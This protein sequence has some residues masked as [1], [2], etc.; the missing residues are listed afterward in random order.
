MEKHSFLIF[1]PSKKKDFVSNETIIYSLWF[2]AIVIFF[3]TDNYAQSNDLVYWGRLSILVAIVAL[4][5]YWALVG[6]WKYR[7]LNGKYNGELEFGED[8]F[9]I[10]DKQIKLNEINKIDIKIQDYHG[11]QTRSRGSAFSPGLSQG[12]N[13]YVEYINQDGTS[14]RVFFKQS[15]K[16]QYRELRTF[17]ISAI[18]LNKI[19]FLRGIDLLGI[20]DYDEIQ[21][22]KLNFC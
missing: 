3:L 7:P 2:L 15:V 16:S 20:E 12:I 21:Q 9:K 8:Y 1:E 14:N 11:M 5:G 19:P 4:S 13:N 6:L 10:N 18:K 17:I 22:F